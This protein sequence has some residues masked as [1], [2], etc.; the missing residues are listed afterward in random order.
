MIDLHTFNRHFFLDFLIFELLGQ[1]KMAKRKDCFCQTESPQALSHIKNN[2]LIA[3][4]TD[5][6][7]T[8]TGSKPGR[9]GQNA[10]FGSQ[11]VPFWFGPKDSLYLS[12]KLR[13]QKALSHIKNNSPNSYNNRS[14]PNPNMIQTGPNRTK[15]I[16]WGPNR[17]VSIEYRQGL[18]GPRVQTIFYDRT[19]PVP[20]RFEKSRFE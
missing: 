6:I 8:Q 2:P 1:E 13:A 19:M 14:N 11:I 9:T 15:C 10:S 18:D 7:Q 5:S 4:V 3:I 12:V 16:V 17:I 20:G